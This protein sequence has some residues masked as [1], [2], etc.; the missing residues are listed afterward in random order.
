VIHVDCNQMSKEN[1]LVLTKC[2]HYRKQ[3]KFCHS[4][5]HL[6]IGEFPGIECKWL[7]LLSN[8][9]SNLVFLGIGVDFKGNQEVWVGEDN[10]V[11]KGIFE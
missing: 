10:F 7:V 11:S 4:V 3:L 6:R 2:F 8:N 9:G 1:T 5:S